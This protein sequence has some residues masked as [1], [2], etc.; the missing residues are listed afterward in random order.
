ME[1]QKQNEETKSNGMELLENVIKSNEKA[2]TSNIENLKSNAKLSADIEDLV[3]A[4][5]QKQLDFEVVK[6]IYKEI[7]SFYELEQIKRVE[8][9]ANIPTKTETVLSQETIDFYGNLERKIK[10]N[11]KF[12]WG[13]F[14]TFILGIFTLIFSINSA[15]TWYKESIKAKTVL[16]Q[17]ILNEIAGEGKRIIDEKE[18][19][20]LKENTEIMQLWIKNNPKKAE[21]FLR[22]KEGFEAR[23]EK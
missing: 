6:E 17:D 13:G 1:N 14:G 12:I 2:V 11:G 8:F 20:I 5:G 9:L 7:L 19:K 23:L 18:I 10:R 16:R 3:L 15:T 4:I 21:D 22:F